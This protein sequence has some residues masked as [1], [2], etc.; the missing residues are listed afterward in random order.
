MELWGLGLGR[1]TLHEALRL[2]TL[3]GDACAGLALAVLTHKVLPSLRKNPQ[4]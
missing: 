3:A 1:T 2:R 4:R